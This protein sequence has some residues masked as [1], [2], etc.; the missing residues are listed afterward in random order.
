MLFKSS[1]PGSLMLLGEYAVLH[2]KQA[3]VCAINKRITVT[4][5]P[6]SDTQIEIISP[7]LGHLVTRIS[8]LTVNPPFQ[9][10][11]AVLKKYQKRL[12][13]GCDITIESEFS[14]TVGLAS[15]AA[16]T[17]ALLSALTTWLKVS[18]S[19]QELIREARDIVQS[20]QRLGSGADVYWVV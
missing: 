2:R 9:F 12:K 17:V 3:L 18:L 10:V 20:V 4:L 13:T 6:R 1:A 8:H 16:V 14:D 11:L 19:P 5:A 15:S 7:T